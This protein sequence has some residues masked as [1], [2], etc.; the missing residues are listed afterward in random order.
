MEKQR[1]EH[2]TSSFG[3]VMAAAGSAIGLGTLWQ[4][5]YMVAQNGGAVFVLTYFICTLFL[6]IPIFIAEIVLGRASQRGAVGTFKELSPKSPFWTISGWLGI[7]AS[8]LVLSFYCVVSGWGLNYFLMSMN[9]YFLKL[10]EAQIGSLFDTLYASASMNLFWQFVF[11]L[12]TV[13]IVYQGIKKGIEYWSKILTT[14]LLL[15]LFGLFIHSLFLDGF[16]KALRFVF[17][18]DWSLVRPATLLSAL[19]LSFF[20]LSLGEGIMITYGSYLE[21]SSD[22]PRTALIVGIVTLL[23]SI[24]SVMMIFPIVFTYDLKVDQGVGLIFQTLPVLFSKMPGRTLLSSLFF[25]TLVFTALTS[26]VGILEALVANWMD[27]SKWSRKKAVIVFGSIT[28]VLGIPVALSGTDLIF[29]N[30][31]AVFGQN[32]FETIIFL[33][34]TWIIPLSGLFVVLFTGWKLEKAKAKSQFCL[35]T[36][37]KKVFSVWYFFIK[38]VAPIAIFLIILQSIGVI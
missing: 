35:G 25:L 2:W 29:A 8:F 16:S 17:V 31:R 22:V 19:G 13:L 27:L 11:M 24:F 36:S 38:W 10:P 9:Q 28:Y 12:M 7:F 4:F 33:V 32:F 37:M 1:R 6:A 26:S 14:L 3:F 34:N 18:P 15:L 21:K 5:P 20:T 23:V 30:W